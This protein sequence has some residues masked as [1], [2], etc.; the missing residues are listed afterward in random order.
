MKDLFVTTETQAAIISSMLYSPRMEKN[1][2]VRELKEYLMLNKVNVR[3]MKNDSSH[4]EHAI[5][6]TNILLRRSDT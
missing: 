3:P 4:E 2:T 5:N 1:Y 6:E